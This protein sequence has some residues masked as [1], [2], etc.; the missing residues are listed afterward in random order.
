[1]FRDPSV[2]FAAYQ[3]PHPLQNDIVIKIQT[4]ERSDPQQALRTAIDDLQ[5]EVSHISQE[6]KAQVEAKRNDDN[7][8]G[9]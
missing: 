7:M 3:H 5:Q 1:M 4:N 6:F 9:L 8:F 2:T